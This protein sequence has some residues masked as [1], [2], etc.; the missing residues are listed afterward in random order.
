MGS[1][2]KKGSQA[3]PE[4]LWRFGSASGRGLPVRLR[5]RRAGA[6]GQMRSPDPVP[7]G[8]DDCQQPLGTLSQVH[9]EVGPDVICT[10]QGRTLRLRRV[11]GSLPR[12]H[13]L[14]VC[15]PVLYSSLY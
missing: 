3:L 5:P 6:L 10:F 2:P 7:L 12:P 15:L 14:S 11:S 9:V 13:S 1:L 4:P 8:T